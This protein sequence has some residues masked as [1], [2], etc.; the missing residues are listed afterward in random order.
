MFPI[1][2]DAFEEKSCEMQTHQNFPEQ[3]EQMVR[4]H[5]SSRPVTSNWP[6]TLLTWDTAAV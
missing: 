2:C 5:R 1:I 6:E 4:I 3:M